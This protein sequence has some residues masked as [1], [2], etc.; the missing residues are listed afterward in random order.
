V[1]FFK[2]QGASVFGIDLVFPPKTLQKYFSNHIVE[3]IANSQH[4]SEFLTK[5]KPD[6]V[7]HCA[8]KCL[9]A[10][11]VEKPE[12]YEEYNVKKAS[13]FLDLCESHGVNRFL[14]SST[15]ATYG[16]PLQSPITETHPQHPINPYGATKLKFEQILL[17]RKNLCVGIFR[18]FNVAGADPKS[19]IG[20]NHHPETHLIP[21]LIKAALANSPAK[22]FGNDYETKDGTCVRDYIHVMDLA[23][24]HWL[25]AQQMIENNQGGIYN[26]GT[27]TGHSILEVLQATEKVLGKKISLQQEPRRAGDPPI[28]VADA[29]SAQKNLGWKINYT[30]EQIIKTAHK[31]HKSQE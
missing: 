28:L 10:E 11:S 29:T 7:I 15:A 21:N 6:L 17:S 1:K 20:E 13:T 22:I 5:I 3:D 26:L 4:V 18:Y 2:K 16:N 8:A 30:L 14:F 31:W 27:T 24:A 19:E 25:L 12:L 9:V 23:N